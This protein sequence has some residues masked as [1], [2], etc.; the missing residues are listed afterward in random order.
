MLYEMLTGTLPYPGEIGEMLR[1]HLY[2]PIEPPSRRNPT[3]PP[4]WEA[5]C[6][7]MLEKAKDARPQSMTEVATAL[8]NLRLHASAYQQAAATRAESSN[9]GRTALLHSDDAAAQPTLHTDLASILEPKPAVAP[10]VAEPQPPQPELPPTDA[11]AALVTD[12]R[13]ANFVATLLVRPPGRWSAVAE[14]CTTSGTAPPHGLPP[15]PLF[16]TWLD[17]PYLD[18]SLCVVLF[19]SLRDGFNLSFICPRRRW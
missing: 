9:S 17:H 18:P 6:M 15:P 7:H 13:H 1:G 10:V 5:L 16:V 2:Q 12:L 19:L 14:L 11:C 8:E 3:I 4:E